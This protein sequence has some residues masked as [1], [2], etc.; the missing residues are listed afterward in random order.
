MP[1]ADTVLLE[2]VIHRRVVEVTVGLRAD[3]LRAVAVVTAAPRADRLRAVA[4]TVGLRAVAVTVG[5]RVAAVTAAHQV[6]ADLLRAVARLP[7]V[8]E[9]LPRR[10]LA[11]RADFRRLAAR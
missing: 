3:L 10:A 6:T 5:L 8:L 7:E 9:E 11:L 4:V 1:P 2:G